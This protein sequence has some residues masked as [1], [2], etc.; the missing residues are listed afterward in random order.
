MLSL[1]RF[2]SILVVALSVL[3]SA[4]GADARPDKESAARKKDSG[5]EEGAARG[6][7]GSAKSKGD[8]KA[9]PAKSKGGAKGGLSRRGGVSIGAPNAGKLTGSIRLKSSRALRQRENAHSWGLPALVHL[10]QRAAGH[11]AKKHKGSVMLV[12]DLSGRTGGPLEGHR[13]HQ[14]GRDADIGFY[15]LNSR[16]KPVNVR[17]FVAFDPSGKGRELP[18]ATF[19]EARNWR[20]IEALLN[21]PKAPVRYV[22]INNALRGRLLAYAARKHMPRESISRVAAAM[23]PARDGDRHD[24]RL[25]VRIACPESM[26]DVCTEESASRGD[27]SRAGRAEEADAAGE[28]AGGGDS[29]PAAPGPE[30]DAKPADL[31]KAGGAGNGPP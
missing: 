21:D 28:K 11:V 17:H 3:A 24:D 23:M 2:G 4:R 14:S 5:A 30:G 26:R 1:R 6:K 9:S 15:V 10:L 25:Q 22:F 13:S 12:G 8:A 20:M 18:W 19:D 27:A 7:H 16:G 29:K 31:P